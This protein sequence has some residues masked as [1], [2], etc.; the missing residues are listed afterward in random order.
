VTTRGLC[1]YDKYSRCEKE[2][3]NK[4]EQDEGIYTSFDRKTHR[5]CQKMNKYGQY[6][7]VAMAIEILGDR[8]TLLIIR[9]LL[10][11]MRHFNDLQRGL[12]G[13]SRG[14]LSDRLS[15]LQEVGVLEKQSH[16]K[17]RKTEYTLTEAG[18][19]LS[20]V[21][22]ALMVWGAKWAFGE[23]TEEQLDP[24][25]LMWWMRD[26]VNRDQLTQ[27]RVVIQFDFIHNQKETYWLVLT[28]DDVSVCLTYPGYETDV[29][30]TADLSVFFQLWLGRI[31]YREAIHDQGIRVDAIPPLVRAFP[32]WFAWSLAA[33]AVRAAR[34]SGD[35]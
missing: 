21:I 11:G 24:V 1:S 6:C 30:V 4:I 27:D 13:I 17:G 3:Q 34:L 2:T 28:R 15:R 25:L 22:N 8:W 23:P 7:P 19:E 9:D 29:L 16:G 20:D 18:V 14:L 32:T 5:R 31:G 12:P 35:A 10:S 26:R 33:P